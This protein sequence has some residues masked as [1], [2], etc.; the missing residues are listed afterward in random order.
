MLGRLT[1]F[2]ALTAALGLCVH[3]AW[4]QHR[5]SRAEQGFDE[6]GKVVDLKKWF[7]TLPLRLNKDKAKGFTALYEFQVSGP[8]GG[9][10]WVRVASGKAHVATKPPKDKPTCI[11]RVSDENWLKIINGEMKAMWAYLTGKL[12]VEGSKD[13][14]NKFGDLFF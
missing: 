7:A 14:A 1:R 9:R 4:A 3:C 8:K 12:R 11:A 10:W 13:H 2:A 5:A 6:N